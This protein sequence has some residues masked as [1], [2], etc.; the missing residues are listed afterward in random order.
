[1]GR[2]GEPSEEGERG[3][4]RGGLFPEPSQVKR[5]REQEREITEST[6]KSKGIGRNR[7]YQFR[8]SHE[9]KD[10]SGG[11][12]M[13]R[14]REEPCSELVEKSRTRG[15]SGV[16][17]RGSDHR[18]DQGEGKGRKTKNFTQLH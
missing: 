14:R 16:Q 3:G 15:E 10:G 12:K 13:S 4:R 11:Q 9:G 18:I 17:P 6:T 8:E 1:V 2:G 5:S 7:T